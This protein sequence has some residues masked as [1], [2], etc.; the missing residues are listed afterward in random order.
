VLPSG[1][2]A[3][4]FSDIEGS[5]Q[6]C[7]SHR[8]ATSS[9]IERLDAI[10]R[11]TIER[12]VGRRSSGRNDT[13]FEYRSHREGSRSLRFTPYA[14]KRARIPLRFALDSCNFQRLR[15]NVRMQA[16]LEDLTVERLAD[17]LREAEHAHA[18]YERHLGH[19]DTD[20]P[21]WYARHIYDRLIED[22]ESRSE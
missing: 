1:T 14:D 12:N 15:D 13:R 4:M 18:I 3:F 8:Y 19:P 2:D 7:N 9:A 21:T 17:L 10:L 11:E 16:K 20:W 5:S 22:E 6:Q